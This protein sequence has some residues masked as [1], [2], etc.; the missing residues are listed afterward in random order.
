MFSVGGWGITLVGNM[1][2]IYFN[3]PDT[4]TPGVGNCS[5]NGV[6]PQDV[7]FLF[8]RDVANLLDTF[9]LFDVQTG[10]QIGS[11]C[12]QTITGLAS[13][14]L[15]KSI[16]IAIGG[17]YASTTGGSLAYLRWQPGLLP[18]GVPPPVGISSPT[19]WLDYEFD[20]S[21]GN[22]NDT[23]GLSQNL[24]GTLTYANTT[25][26]SPSCSAG[27]QQSVKTGT[28][29]ALSGL[30][31]PLYGGTTISYLWS[32]TSG[33]GSLSSTTIANPNVTGLST[34]GTRV[35]HLVC[36]DGAS[37][38]TSAD[39][40]NGVVIA[41]SNGVIDLTA[42]G[43]SVDAQRILNP[44]P[45]NPPTLIMYGANTWP[46]GDIFQKTTLDQQISNMANSYSAWWRT[47]LAGT[48]TL[49]NNS[50]TVTG[51]GTNLLLP[52]GGSGSTPLPGA[53]L[54]INYPGTD[55]LSHWTEAPIASC[56]SATSITLGVKW[57]ASPQAPFPN[58]PT[59][60]HW[61][62]G[63]TDNSGTYSPNDQFGNWIYG[64]APWNYYDVGKS[65]Y[66]FYWRSGIDTYLTFF[67]NLVDAWWEF[68]N[69]DQGASCDLNHNADYNLCWAPAAYRSMSMAEVY[70]RA[71]EQGGSSN[72]WPGI[73]SI[74]GLAEFSL[75]L[76][77]PAYPS[78]DNREVSYALGII[79]Y[80]GFVDPDPTQ[81]ASSKLAVKNALAGVF[82]PAKQTYMGYTYWPQF[83]FDNGPAASATSITSLGGQGSVCLTNGS[84]NVIG[85]GTVWSTSQNFGSSTQMWFFDVAGNPNS[86]PLNNS[87][88]DAVAY[89]ATI[90]N[91][92]LAHLSTS[93]A[94][95]T[96]CTGTSG[97]N[98]GYV[99][100]YW[101]GPGATEMA[102]GVLPYQVGML[103][104]SFYES[105]YL[106]DGY[107]AP[108][109]ALYR[110]YGAN[111]VDFSIQY[112]QAPLPVG[113]IY[114]SSLTIGCTRPT[115]NPVCDISTVMPPY[116]DS[117]TLSLD[118]L[119]AYVLRYQDD[120]D[121]AT[122]TNADLLMSQMLSCPGSGGPNPDGYCISAFLPGGGYVTG[123]PPLGMAPKWAGQLAGYEQLADMWPAV[124]IP[125]TPINSVVISGG[126]VFS[127]GVV[128]Q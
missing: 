89:G 19:S 79:T 72:M 128:I 125:A 57:P 82:T 17:P 44:K 78:L 100:G 96:A 64:P 113:S 108:S 123:T 84:I 51:S 80:D 31:L 39:I 47:T 91:G 15:I 37:N 81:K 68:P 16:G 93:Y 8:R 48:I 59:A 43:L 41:D 3:A 20:P 6:N 10:I 54:F 127:G 116:S 35:F 1:E 13:D 63:T 46:D 58:N 122:K 71:I 86:Q 105:A 11:T 38:S 95:P 109:A 98:R 49:T 70:L 29:M 9:E 2:Q 5:I 115:T 27:T 24:S 87:F 117:R 121:S 12:V 7:S 88:G 74:V 50:F 107:D 55:G 60:I 34:F 23:S 111:T 40:R 77:N 26:Y 99:V 66:Q 85:T 33:S 97:S 104:A 65:A 22:K 61:Q 18:R 28:T 83:F 67:D 103:G 102:W 53:Y 56:N 62:W 4:V 32:I 73:R 69:L 14:A 30:G 76:F 106:M 124:R 114:S 101:Q 120:G 52:C 112:G 42:E 45:G 90:V 118:I 126:V 110:I 75:G 94:G 21:P 36:T 119:K 25:I 92:T